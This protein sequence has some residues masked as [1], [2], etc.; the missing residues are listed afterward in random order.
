[1]K[2][3]LRDALRDERRRKCLKFKPTGCLESLR[4]LVNKDFVAGNWERREARQKPEFFI[5]LLDDDK[6]RERQAG[7]KVDGVAQQGDLASRK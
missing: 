2:V 7:G 1:M 4:P 5:A 6:L 3:S